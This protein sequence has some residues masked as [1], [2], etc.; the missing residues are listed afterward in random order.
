MASYIERHAKMING[1]AWVLNATF[2]DAPAYCQQIIKNRNNEICMA[3]TRPRGK[4]LRPY[5]S[6]HTE[7]WFAIGKRCEDIKHALDAHC[8]N[9]GRLGR[10]FGFCE[11]GGFFTPTLEYVRDPHHG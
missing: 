1:A 8:D 2:R 5:F 6:M 7:M 4:R 10:M 9:C 11:C 3:F